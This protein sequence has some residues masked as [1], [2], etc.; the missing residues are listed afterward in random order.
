MVEPFPAVSAATLKASQLR[1][2]CDPTRLPFTTTTE[3][4]DSPLVL[5]QNRAV[6]SIQFGIGMRRHGY[7]L[8]ALGSTGAGK[9]AIVRRFLEE[10]AASEPL[11]RDWCYVHN[12]EQPHRPRAMSLPKGMGVKF[13]DDIARFVEDLRTAITAALETEEYRRQHQQIHDEFK[14]RRD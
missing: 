4:P 1:Q 10:H 8:F 3:L 7:N 9:H 6:A 14:A 2:R 12:F 5:G 11:A 13:R